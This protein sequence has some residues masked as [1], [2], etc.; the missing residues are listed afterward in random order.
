[1]KLTR[2]ENASDVAGA[3]LDEASSAEIGTEASDVADVSD[4]VAR[5]GANDPA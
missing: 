2:E 4:A 3:S 5:S 1:M